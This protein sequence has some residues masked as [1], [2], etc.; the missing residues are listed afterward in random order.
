MLTLTLA[1]VYY[2]VSGALLMNITHL[3]VLKAFY[4]RDI[5]GKLLHSCQSGVGRVG[6]RAR[7]YRV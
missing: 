3:S 5:A 4:L 2:T 6:E 7:R 1:D